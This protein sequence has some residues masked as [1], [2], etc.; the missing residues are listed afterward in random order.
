MSGGPTGPIL[1][2]R[3][4]REVSLPPTT[5]MPPGRIASDLIG[6]SRELENLDVLVK[7]LHSG[8]SGVLVL[9]GPAGAGKT[10]LLDALAVSA[11]DCRLERVAGVEAERELPFAGLHL[12]LSPFLSQ[13]K[14]LPRPQ[15]SALAAAFGQVDGFAPKPFMIGL[16]TLTLLSEQATRQRPV[17]CLIDDAHWLDP[18]TTQTLSFVARRIHAEPVALIFAVRGVNERDNFAGLPDLA[19]NGLS[20]EDAH[21]LLA[22][23][24]HY[25]LDLAVQDRIVAEADG[26]PRALVELP[27]VCSPTELAYGFGRDGPAQID[28][29]TEA[30]FIKRVRRLPAETRRLM[31]VAAAEPTGDVALLW[32]A[33][34]RLGLTPI[35]AAPAESAGLLT[36]GSRAQFRHPLARSAVYRAA[37]PQQRRAVHRALADST[38]EGRDKDRRAWHRAQATVGVDDRVAD[39]LE[40]TASR[41][42]T[43][44]GS[45]AAAE[46]LLDS[47]RLTAEPA[48][49]AHRALDAAVAK[50]EAGQFEDATNLLGV[51]RSGPLSALDRSRALLLDAELNSATE[52]SREATALL[53]EAAKRLERLD[54]DRARDTYLEAFSASLFEGPPGDS[55][56]VR[57]IASA[58]LRTGSSDQSDRTE[59][60]RDLLL[61]GMAMLVDR[62]YEAAVPILRSALNAFIREPI[63]DPSSLRWLW[64]ASRIARGLCDE[65]SWGHLTQRHLALAREL[66]AVS[67]LPLALTERFGFELMTGNPSK[68]RALAM[69]SDAVLHAMDCPVTSPS[70]LWLE[71]WHGRA[72][73]VDD[74]IAAHDVEL[75]SN[76]HRLWHVSMEWGIANMLNGLG[77]YA[78]ALAA[79]E[80][81][82][83]DVDDFGLSTVWVSHELIEAAVRSGNVER[84]RAPLDR[85]ALFARSSG[86]DWA[87]GVELRCRALV[88]DPSSAEPHYRAAIDC[89]DRSNVRVAAARSHLLFG[90]WLRRESRV[91]EARKHLRIAEEWLTAIGMDGFAR[92]ARR[93]LSA[94]GERPHKRSEPMPGELTPQEEQIARLAIEG[95]T[96]T[97]IGAL[98]FLSA[99][100]VEWH[101]RKVFMKLDVTSRRQLREKQIDRA[102]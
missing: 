91:T 39:Q 74:L 81:A 3:G 57:K 70:Q 54:P 100:T 47:T 53:L 21:A 32:R 38:E 63:N 58:L 1:L 86:T 43:R 77:R 72:E 55:G 75:K 79:A 9:R 98:L 13:L 28:N 19:V 64:L 102:D 42:R 25:P 33:A 49:R 40:S 97:E 24:L 92:R 7:R 2:P 99:R 66:G 48:R 89:L 4:I 26:N 31:L 67:A 68:A 101:M 15:R 46:F 8:Q 88:S 20:D 37:T 6:R 80:R 22:S 30:A 11:G 23:V 34:S 50:Q 5:L 95:H 82:S 36:L 85:L 10:A 69:E 60:G 90:E 65:R 18:A 12:L 44:G 35:S 73:S 83:A 94:S 14:R 76:R 41:A 52:P 51:A 16:A 29:R 84:A 96:N 45:A 59:T 27:D 62:G 56:A 78:E 71:I 61:Y 17:V 87:I 93:E